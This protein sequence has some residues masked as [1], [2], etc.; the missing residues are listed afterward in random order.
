MKLADGHWIY[1]VH[2]V[3]SAIEASPRR[4][5][6]LWVAASRP[7]VG[8][9]SAV[10]AAARAANISVEPVQRGDLDRVAA[11]VHQGVAALCDVV[12]PAGEKELERR[13][14]E[15]AAPF[16][17]ILEGVQD[18]RNLGACLRTAE[19][20]GVDA[21]LLHQRNAA[22]LTPAAAKA[23]SGAL[24]RLFI[25]SVTNVARRI[26]WLKGHG[27]WVV[28]GDNRASA[29][30]F[31]EEIAAPVAIALGGEG[32]GLRR[33]TRER[34]DLLVRIP[35]AGAVS[36]LNVSVAAGVLLFE[37]ARRRR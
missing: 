31:D 11:G 34:C 19:A 15:F 22:S 35:M 25:V 8:A 4:V 1:G 28:G 26:E 24:E 13:W 30:V 12:A 32:K 23:A 36:S 27:V 6:R 20:A 37:V 17:L 2:A 3:R 5:R 16:L 14:D 21:V 18:P 9:L 33:L 29:S 7:P 10:L